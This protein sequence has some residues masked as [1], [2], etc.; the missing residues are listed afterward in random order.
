MELHA[1]SGENEKKNPVAEQAER[2]RQQWEAARLQEVRRL[3]EAGVYTEEEGKDRGLI[4][5][6]AK[7]S[8]LATPSHGRSSAQPNTKPK[9]ANL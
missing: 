9:G 1:M 3:V 6:P 4:K 2:R 5:P 8:E 7:T